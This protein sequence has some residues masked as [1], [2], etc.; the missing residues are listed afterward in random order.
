MNT[1]NNPFVEMS[2]RVVPTAS[3]LIN[4]RCLYVFLGF[5]AIWNFGCASRSNEDF[6]SD[7]VEIEE[8]IYELSEVDVAPRAIGSE[9][10]TDS[11]RDRRNW[12]RVRLRFVV[13]KE[14]IPL[15]VEVKSIED[16]KMAKFVIEAVLNCRFEPATINGDPVYCRFEFST[17]LC[18]ENKIG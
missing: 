5:L 4:L 3:M 8:K 15:N 2:L 9:T 17:P 13:S 16:V 7:F 18:V 1:S 6:K 12:I 14:G 10:P 11:E